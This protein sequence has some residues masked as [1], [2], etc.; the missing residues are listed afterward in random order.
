MRT[1]ILSL[2]SLVA[3]AS[4][5]LATNDTHLKIGNGNWFLGFDFQRGEPGFQYTLT[6]HNAADGANPVSINNNTELVFHYN[7]YVDIGFSVLAAYNTTLGSTSVTGDILSDGGNGDPWPSSTP[8]FSWGKTGSLQFDYDGFY[9]WIKCD[10]FMEGGFPGT[11]SIYWAASP[12]KNLPS[13]CEEVTLS[14]Y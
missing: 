8:G 5:A 2:F 9:G 14:K 10:A 1:S 12:I 13:H 6:L 3:A 7:E 11:K 4:P